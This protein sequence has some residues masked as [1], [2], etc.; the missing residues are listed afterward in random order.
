MAIGEFD[1]VKTG[2]LIVGVPV[3]IVAVLITL[4]NVTGGYKGT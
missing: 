1:P 2:L 4:F 3:A